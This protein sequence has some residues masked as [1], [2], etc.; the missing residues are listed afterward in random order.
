MTAA[1]VLCGVDGSPHARHAGGVAPGVISVVG[2]IDVGGTADQDGKEMLYEISH[3]AG[4]GPA[5][6]TK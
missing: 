4:P 6:C 2:L 5:P 3:P 1:E